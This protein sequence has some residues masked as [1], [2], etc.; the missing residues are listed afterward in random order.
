TP[1]GG[2]SMPLTE[3]EKTARVRAFFE[4]V[5]VPAAEQLRSRGIQFFPLGFEDAPTW[6]VPYAPQT[7][8]LDE[9][10]P[11]DCEA[12]LRQ[13]W[14][15]ESLPELARLAKPLIELAKELEAKPDETGEVSEFIYEMF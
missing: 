7:P 2:A 15:A 5:L 11:G 10:Q 3:E 1:I 12:R 4:E 8:E 6:Y 9:V 14:E 13:L